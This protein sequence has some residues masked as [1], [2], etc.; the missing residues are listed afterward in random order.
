M[1]A[2][3]TRPNLQPI[4]QLAQGQV[5]QRRFRTDGSHDTHIDQE[6]PQSDLNWYIHEFDT[7]YAQ[8]GLDENWYKFHGI[9]FLMNAQMHLLPEGAEHDSDKR[10]TWAEQTKRDI[11]GF[12]LEYLSKGLV[13]SYKYKIE[14]GQLVDPLYGNRSAI[15]MIDTRERGGVVRENMIKTQDFFLNAPDGAMA[16]IPSPK[17]PSGLITD[18]GKAIEYLTSFWFVMQKQGKEIIGSTIKTDFT[19]KDYRKMIKTLTGQDLPFGASLQ[20]FVRAIAHINPNDRRDG[21]KTVDDVIGLMRQT[22]LDNGEEDRAFEGRS[23]SEVYDG[24]AKGEALYQFNTQTQAFVQQF[25][26]YV[27]QGGHSR[28]ELQKAVGATLLRVS[29]IFLSEQNAAG[30]NK[31]LI[32]TRDERSNVFAADGGMSFG[33]VFAQ[34]KEIEGCAGG[35]KSTDKLTA[36]MT[37][38]GPRL[39]RTEDALNRDRSNWFHCPH[40]DKYIEPPVGNECPPRKGGCGY[41]KQQFKDENPGVE[42]C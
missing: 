35:G 21:V 13:F 25:M 20:D 41:T 24:V 12:C 36:I 42:V 5:L 40:C 9:G 27:Q 10:K 14:N 22:K 15:E 16:V 17:G 11:L 7:N 23:W 32:A 8:H 28:L 38:N 4:G 1:E 34:V 39:A 18:D 19:N 30:I 26:D 29:K 31:T 6:P 2:V 33:Q 3:A 37:I